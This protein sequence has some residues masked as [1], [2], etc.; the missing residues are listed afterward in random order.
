MTD[1]KIHASPTKEFFIDM[2]TRDIALE[3]CIFDLLDN[4]IDGANRTRGAVSEDDGAA[5]EGFSIAV[6][7]DKGHFSIID[8][9]GGIALND[10]IDY[11]FHF[12]KPAEAPPDGVDSI[13]LYGIGMKRA[14]FKMGKQILVESQTEEHSYKIGIDVDKWAANADDWDFEFDEIEKSETHGTKISINMLKN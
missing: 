9:C 12:G 7:L 6:E 8:N 4:C 13:G 10:A 5:F 1:N 2:L 14:M 11:A 3:D